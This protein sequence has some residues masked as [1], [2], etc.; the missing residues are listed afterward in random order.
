MPDEETWL[1]SFSGDL[2]YSPDLEEGKPPFKLLQ[3]YDNCRN[4]SFQK[5]ASYK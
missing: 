1:S 5:Y 4:I 2:M 3:I